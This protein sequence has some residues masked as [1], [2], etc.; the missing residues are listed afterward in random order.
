MPS[1]VVKHRG[2]QQHQ[3]RARQRVQQESEQHATQRSQQQVYSSQSAQQ[4]VAR[5]SYVVHSHRGSG[6]GSSSSSGGGGGGRRDASP[7]AAPHS[8]P[9]NHY[10]QH[11]TRAAAV[12]TPLTAARASVSRLTKLSSDL[13]HLAAKLDKFENRCDVPSSSQ[14]L[15]LDKL[16]S[17]R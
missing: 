6:N 16:S 5:A 4:A 17:N 12:A 2:L 13:H 3:H 9:V 14:N 7:A 11:S 1:S 10:V 15:P 8:P